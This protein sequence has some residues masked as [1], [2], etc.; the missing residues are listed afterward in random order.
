MHRQNRKPL[1]WV[2][3]LVLGALASGA[4]A[5]S[6]ELPPPVK[7]PGPLE[8]VPGKGPEA[9]VSIM[10]LQINATKM[11]E[12]S[13]KQVISEVRVE[14]PKVAR[15]Q[16]IIDNPRAVLV[17][18]LA[19]GT[20]RLVLSDANKTSEALDIRVSTDDEIVR[21]Q[22]RKDFLDMVRKAVPTAAVDA[23]VGP[24]N[25]VMISG[26]VTHTE[27]VGVVLEIA[28]S[29]FGPTT[30]VVN[31]LRVGGVHQ[32]QLEVTV[33]VVNRSE[34]RNL[35]FSFINKRP[36]NFVAS[37]FS[38]PL[39]LASTLTPAVGAAAQTLTAAPNVQ[40]GVL[41]DKTGFSGFLE[42]LRTENLAKILSE[43]RVVT[44]SGR[45]AYINS[46]GE[47]PILT[48][49]GLGT[50]NVTYKQFGTLVSFLPVVLGNGKI[51]L[52][53]RPEISA[54]N[55]AAGISIAGGATTIPGFDVR[56]AQVAVQME[57]GQ[58]LAIGGLIQTT[59]NS[60][61][62]KV[63][64]LGDIPYLNVF[65]SGKADTIR[66][67]ELLILV[68][69]RLIDPLD[70]TQVPKR[71]PGQ[72]TRTADDF[73][74]FLEGIME[75]PRGTRVVRDGHKF[76]PAYKGSPT[77]GVLPTTQPQNAF[78]RNGARG[79]YVGTAEYTETAPSF[80]AIGAPEHVSAPASVPQ[81]S[82]P[83]A[84]PVS[85]QPNLPD[86][87]AVSAPALRVP[88]PAGAGSPNGTPFARYSD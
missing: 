51:H 4:L 50:P 37:V 41:G 73:E 21:E 72:E 87:N 52:E 65:F 55:N 85:R 25:G 27:S 33:A 19:P 58:T 56:S 24:N 11:I 45:P 59:V 71:L 62:R 76:V 36:D 28:R 17:T 32:V 46:G 47:T 74:L 60:S 66:E 29:V 43:P 3:T 42:A 35:S 69:P 18:G 30:N 64:L 26:G 49:S 34:L 86:P 39:S 53:V 6:Q 84:A 5:F 83:A 67:E 57:D 54:I 9:N 15:V 61:I 16:S 31:G 40:F 68:T 12:M 63:P 82:M 22:L 78:R 13:K 2:W 23:T 79:G 48:T 80:H 88:G 8:P 75:A 1:A 20:T 10:V 7:G 81:P 44:L 70:C 38:S 77:A 14:N